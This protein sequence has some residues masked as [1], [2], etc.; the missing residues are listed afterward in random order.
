MCEAPEVKK[1]TV[2][3]NS[4]IWTVRCDRFLEIVLLGCIMLLSLPMDRALPDDKSQKKCS[5]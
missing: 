5:V 2:R 1:S 3:S 4:G